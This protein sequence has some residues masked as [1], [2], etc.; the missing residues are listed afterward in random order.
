MWWLGRTNRDIW[1]FPDLVLHLP[2]LTKTGVRAAQRAFTMR[3][4][5]PLS[6]LSDAWQRSYHRTIGNEC[7]GL[8]VQ[9]GTSGYF[10]VL[11]L[12]L[13]DL[14]KTGVTAAQPAFTMRN[15]E[16]LNVLSDAWQ[17]FYDRTFCNECDCLGLHMGTSDNFPELVLHLPDLTMT[18][19]TAAH[20]EFTMRNQAPMS[21]L[22]DAWH[23]D[24]ITE[25][26]AMNVIA[27]A[28][29]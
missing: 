10:P 21:V 14:T 27:W 22:S 28:Y 4:Q 24:S 20:R 8:V 1:L 26:F 12:H 7:D 2:D 11:V 9:I 15:Q 23:N 19:V 5:E 3:N 18:G 13:P 17:G 6:V 16:P 25:Q 29:K